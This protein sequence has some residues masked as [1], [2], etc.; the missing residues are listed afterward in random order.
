MSL[1]LTVR[2]LCG[3]A[4][5]A[6]VMN[7]TLAEWPPH[8]D[9]IFMA[10][11]AAYFEGDRTHQERA[12]LEWLERLPA[13]VLYATS[14]KPQDVHQVYVPVNDVKAPRLRSNRKITQSQVA[15]GLQLLPAQRPRQPR[16]FPAAV[17][18]EDTVHFVWED[19]VPGTHIQALRQLC[20]RV[21][22]VGHSSSPV[23]MWVSEEAPSLPADAERWLRL[24]P[25]TRGVGRWR[26]R[27][28]C[29]GRLAQLAAAY[30]RGQRPPIVPA[31]PYA[32]WT[33]PIQEPPRPSSHF[34]PDLI[35]LRQTDGPVFGLHSTL[36]LTHHLRNMIMRSCP[37]PV[38]EWVSG[39]KPEG[40]PS[41]RATGHLALVPLPHVGREHADGHLLGM[42]IVLPRD[43]TLQ[44]AGKC[45]NPLLFDEAGWP[46]P[47]RLVMGRLG[48]CTLELADQSDYRH[49]LDPHTWV[50]PSQ[51]WATVTPYCL[52]RHPKGKR[53]AYWRAVEDLIK[54]ACVRIGLPEPVH[55]VATP[56]PILAG[57][58]HVREMPR[59]QR[60]SDG[61]QIE[62]VHAVLVFDRAVH[63]PIIIGAGRYRGYGFCRPLG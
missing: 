16:T 52:D 27:V 44:E 23:Q 58:P 63:G 25:D 7:R 48:E 46:R 4:V 8:P 28:P 6:H 62:H 17:P 22:Y 15:Q 38:P 5:A 49:A 57:V 13:P 60:K 2:Y 51:R 12:A 10:L 43:I 55:V 18:L 26:L 36:Q 35:V 19:A 45:L 30:E 59:V 21:T 33:N 32:T 50:G 39:H 47:I 40:G 31:T 41:E 61:G 3:R 54:A 56:A 29:P 20:T 34:S 14:C 9:R 53:E 42:A 24:R 37:Q 11:A 1:T